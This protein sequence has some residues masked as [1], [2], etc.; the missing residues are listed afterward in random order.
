MCTIRQVEVAEA[1][2]YSAIVCSPGVYKDIVSVC[3]CIADQPM[4][5]SPSI[6]MRLAAADKD[7]TP[8]TPMLNFLCNTHG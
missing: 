8:L 4:S 3:A 1:L 6:G 5:L 2:I 7:F